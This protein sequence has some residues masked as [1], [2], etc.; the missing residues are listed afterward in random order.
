MMAA[1][2]AKRNQM[3]NKAD[4]TKISTISTKFPSQSTSKVITTEIKLPD[5]IGVGFTEKNTSLQKIMPISDV[6]SNMNT[7]K[8][9]DNNMDNNKKLENNIN[10]NKIT[11][12]I[13]NCN[14]N[15]G[16]NLN[17]NIVN[18]NMND[19]QNIY[20][21]KNNNS[22]NNN[23]N[24][25]NEKI[26]NMNNYDMINNNNIFISRDKEIQDLKNELY[27]ANKIIEEQKIQIKDLQNQLN[28]ININNYNSIQSFIKIIN[29]KD[30]ELNK[31]K[32]VLNNNNYC[33]N[34]LK[35]KE[36]VYKEEIMS[37]NFISTDQ[38]IHFSIPCTFNDIFAEIEEKLY[39][40]F[41]KYRETNNHF[42]ANG[43]EVLRF[44]TIGQNKIGNGLP[45]TMV[46]P[47]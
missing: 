21:L 29:Q 9:T 6:Y 27:Q 10:N 19:N 47:S 41:P 38:N 33:S 30:E 16:N 4:N 40:Q 18:Y 25:D 46:I 45:V 43:Q 7:N 31:L 34:N 12:N 39:R 32:L 26:Y 5:S 28:N 3:K 1:I 37:V 23:M 35:N 36:I 15:Y 20:N 8:M 2:M 13:N 17:Y 24:N 22:N 44:K 42:L 11:N 14:M